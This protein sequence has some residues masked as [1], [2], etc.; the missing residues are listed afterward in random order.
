MA[1]LYAT[2]THRG[3]QFT[4]TGED[5]T[6]VSSLSITFVSRQDNTRFVGSGSFGATTVFGA[7]TAG[8]YSTFTYTPSASDVKVANTG[9]W[10]VQIKATFADTTVDFSTPA[11]I[12]ILQLL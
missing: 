3:L 12:E 8:V 5:L 2:Q 9:E 7:G 10:K 1:S 11:V 6:S 4:W